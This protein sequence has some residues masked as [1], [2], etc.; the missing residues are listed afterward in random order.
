M[1]KFPTGAT[2]LS[3]LLK[4]RSQIPVL[5]KFINKHMNPLLG[6]LGETK[7]LIGPVGSKQEGV[8]GKDK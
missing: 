4:G 1:G 7:T 3:K 2:Q 6:A 5:E 8:L